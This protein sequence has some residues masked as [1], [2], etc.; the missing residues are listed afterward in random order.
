MHGRSYPGRFVWRRGWAAGLSLA[1]AIAVPLLAPVVVA[2][3]L[4]GLAK[5]AQS[6]EPAV[7]APAAPVSPLAPALSRVDTGGAAPERDHAMFAPASSLP[8]TVGHYDLRVATE[9]P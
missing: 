3:G 8:T 7:S 2:G 4:I 1:L 6:V 9:R 5:M